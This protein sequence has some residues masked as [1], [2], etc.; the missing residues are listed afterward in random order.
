[1]SGF[2]N[3]GPKTPL[4][5]PFEASLLP[6]NAGINVLGSIPIIGIFIGIKRIAAISEYSATFGR[7]TGVNRVI[8]E[9]LDDGNYHTQS[10]TSYTRGHYFRGIAE[11]LGLGI[12]LTILEFIASIFQTI[13]L[14]ALVLIA[15]LTFILIIPITFVCSVVLDLLPRKQII[16]KDA[17]NEMSDSD[18]AE[19]VKDKKSDWSED[20]VSLVSI[21]KKVMKEKVFSF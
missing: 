3:L 4:G 12:V 17:F 10:I 11:I 9:D 5:S 2:I 1:M 8:I 16:N 15:L 19:R 21:F 20:S 18:Y 7:D 14:L 6:D 13:I